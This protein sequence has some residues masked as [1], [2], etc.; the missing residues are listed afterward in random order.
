MAQSTAVSRR[1]F[2][3]QGLALGAAGAAAPVMAMTPVDKGIQWDE[4]FEVV[5]VGSGLAGTCAAISAIENGVKS[6]VMLEKLPML[7]GTSAISGL[8]FA[9]VNSHLQKQQGIEDSA[10]LF[11]N[12]M[13]KAGG[14]QN[15]YELTLKMA[16]TTTRALPWAIERGAQ[17]H[18]K[19]KFL[20]GHSVPR[21]LYPIGGGGNGILRPLRRYFVETL[22]GQ[23]RRRTKFEKIYRDDDGRVVGIQV[24]ENYHFDR[25]L[26][27]DDRENTSGVYK[28][29]RITKGLVMASG[30]YSRDVEFRSAEFPN[31]REYIPAKTA[32]GATSGALKSMIA[33]GAHPIHM[34]LMRFSFKIPTE[35]MKWGTMVDPKTGKRFV[36][37]QNNRQTLAEAICY[38]MDKNGGVFPRNIYDQQGIDSFHDKQRL[39]L[40]LKEGTI[41]KYDTLEALCDAEGINLTGL[42]ATLAEYNANIKAGTDPLFGKNVAELNGVTV[43][44][45]PFYAIKTQPGFTYTQGGVRINTA[46]QVIDINTQKPIPGFYACGEATGGMFGRIRLTSCSCPDAFS[47]GIIAGEEV[48]KA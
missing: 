24:R 6:L 7:G 10:E 25:T 28:N 15:H 16:E 44:Q 9:V 27:N 45:A 12:D 32:I 42:K 4:T 14:Y 35:D 21:T 48:A 30:G 11:A 18:D 3:K 31:I 47:F 46:A 2:L 43:E 41:V 13:S 36:N 39:G 23:I 19:L 17:F 40:A 1:N 26:A 8:N 37:E 34:S 29:Y 33:A 38:M 22:N 5:V 20:G